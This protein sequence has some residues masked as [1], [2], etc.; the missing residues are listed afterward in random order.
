M[1]TNYMVLSIDCF[2]FKRPT[3]NCHYQKHDK[4]EDENNPPLRKK[5]IRKHRHFEKSYFI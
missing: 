3:G 4:M 5:N 2:N 1:P